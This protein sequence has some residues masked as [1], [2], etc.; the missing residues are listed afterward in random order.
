M[1]G[2]DSLLIIFFWSEVLFKTV[3]STICYFVFLITELL[4]M[5]NIWIRYFAV[6]MENSLQEVR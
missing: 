3:S 5:F 2:Q 4:I 6:A 1:I